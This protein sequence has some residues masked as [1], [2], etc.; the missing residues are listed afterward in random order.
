MDKKAKTKSERKPSE[1][2]IER[3]NSQGKKM[4][5]R[6]IDNAT[7]LHPKVG[8]WGGESDG[9]HPLGRRQHACRVH[10]ESGLLLGYPSPFQLELFRCS[11]LVFVVVVCCLCG[12]NE[13]KRR[14]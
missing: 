9:R 11:N 12:C 10:F 8:S 14:F 1:V 3:V 7:R 5:F 2:I 4:K 13:N 6:I